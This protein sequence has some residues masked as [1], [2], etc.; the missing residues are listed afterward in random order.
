MLFRMLWP[1]S[2][3]SSSPLAG[4]ARGFFF[5]SHCEDIVEVL[6]VKLTKVYPTS[7]PLLGSAE[8]FLT[9]SCLHGASSNSSSTIQFLSPGTSNLEVSA[10]GF[11]SYHL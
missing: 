6:E 3:G 1:I 9:Q 10:H 8:E 2:N 7:V 11:C 5:T 4:N